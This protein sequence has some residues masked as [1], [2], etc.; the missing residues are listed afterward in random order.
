MNRAVVH[1]VA[2]WQEADTE[3]RV[4][5]ATGPSGAE[6]RLATV[7]AAGAA[8]EASSV[9]ADVRV[10]GGKLKS[11]AEMQQWVERNPGCLAAGAAAVENASLVAP[12]PSNGLINQVRVLERPRVP[13]SPS[14]PELLWAM[15]TP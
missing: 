10:A 13:C 2:A 7:A 3:A 11:D 8:T 9:R 14:L 12:E 6:A 4:E 5:V 15:S 1:R